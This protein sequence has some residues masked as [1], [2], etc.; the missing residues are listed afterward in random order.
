[1]TLFFFYCCSTTEARLSRITY[2][3]QL[4]IMYTYYIYYL[5]IHLCLLNYSM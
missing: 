2:K 3:A 5:F 4:T 1:M